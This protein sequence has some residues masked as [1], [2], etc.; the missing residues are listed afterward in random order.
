MISY[1]E[2]ILSESSGNFQSSLIILN[3][4]LTVITCQNITFN[5]LSSST[6]S[7]IWVCDTLI[8]YICNDKIHPRK[9]KVLNFFDKLKLNQK[10][11]IAMHSRNM[12]PAMYLTLT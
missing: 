9:S 2:L 8:K 1:V 3:G 11:D 6:F 7:P 12:Q 4:K 5:L 10:A